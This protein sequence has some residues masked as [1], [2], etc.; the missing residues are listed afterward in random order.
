MMVVKVLRAS[1]AFDTIPPA[2]FIFVSITIK[3]K[4]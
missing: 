2:K 3:Y 4:L 1:E